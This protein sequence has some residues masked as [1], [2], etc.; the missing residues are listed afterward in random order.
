MTSP[1]IDPG[2][3]ATCTTVFTQVA[4]CVEELALTAGDG[5]LVASLSGRL[6][7][8][9]L[10]VTDTPAAVVSALVGGELSSLQQ[11]LTAQRA[12][13]LLPT[14][15]VLEGLL[16]GT[17]R[18]VVLLPLR[19]GSTPV[20]TAWLLPRTGA[21]LSLEDLQ[22]PVRRLSELL[23]CTTS[24]DGE[25][26]LAAC[27]DGRP[28]ARLPEALVCAAR[29]WVAR[30]GADDVPPES[31]LRALAAVPDSPTLRHRLVRRDRCVYVVL[32][33]GRR[34]S[35]AQVES[36]VQGLVEA[37]AEHVGREVSAG[38]SEPCDG[39]AL[40]GARE[41]ADLAQRFAAPGSCAPLAAVRAQVVL[42]QVGHALPAVGVDPLAALADY[43]E[44][45]GS[46]LRR[47]LRVWLDAFGDVPSATAALNVH[48]NTLRYRLRRIQEITGVDLRHDAAGR[49]ELHLRLH[50][51]TDNEEH[52]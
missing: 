52:A 5:C 43:D 3:R 14:G 12:V 4:A 9:Q 32:A 51:A 31:V 33:G 28:G 34:T 44:R 1:S 37:V 8:H 17:S 7:A 30:V 6:V 38:L 24:D 15:A 48:S 21:T 18:R 16:E 20:G 39:A 19:D 45:R 41:Q 10:T 29:L 13:G 25:P 27:L 40:P 23:A 35:V 42:Q 22:G 49:L 46:E 36:C 2:P 47:T 11:V 50:V 26:S